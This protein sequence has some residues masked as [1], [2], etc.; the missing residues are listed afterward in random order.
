MKTQL[1]EQLE[2]TQAR[3]KEL[4]ERFP[5]DELVKISSI[6]NLEC[7]EERLMKEI[8]KHQKQTSPQGRR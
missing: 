5:D 3:I 2:I 7:M 1:Q 6:A 4:K 8:V